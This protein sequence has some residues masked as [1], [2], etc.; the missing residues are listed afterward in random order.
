[1]DNLYVEGSSA[2]IAERDADGNTYE[3]ELAALGVRFE[4]L[5]Y[6]WLADYRVP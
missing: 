5:Q 6:Y 4:K 3:A 1:M 2:P